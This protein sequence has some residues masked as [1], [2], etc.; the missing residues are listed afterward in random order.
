M[1][2]VR[3]G[4]RYLAGREQRLWVCLAV[5]LL[6]PLA[7]AAVATPALALAFGAGAMILV[8]EL[9]RRLRNTRNGRL[10]E[11]IVTDALR[12]LPDDYCLV[13]DVVLGARRGNVDHVLIGPCGVVAIETKRLAGH[14]RCQGDTWYAKGRRRGSIS[15][16]VNAGATAVRYVLIERHPELRDSV[17]RWVESIIVF[18][19][20][21][22][23][24]E[25]DRPRA[26]VVRF[27]ELREVVVALAG[28]RRVPPA[29]AEQLA[30][31]LVSVAGK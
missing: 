21:L 4:G 29:I 16:Q 6:V 10:G 7:T 26:T 3:V 8:P 15:K 22:C 1:H 13:N 18:T 19:H 9:A 23:R 17:L 30:R 5:I 25:V 14:I 2:V 11:R 28:R 12:R 27:S 31:S 20:P 24:L